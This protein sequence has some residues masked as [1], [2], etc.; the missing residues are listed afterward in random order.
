MIRWGEEKRNAD[1]GY[2]CRLISQGPGSEKP[3][4]I[5]SDARRKTDID[6]FMVVKSTSMDSLLNWVHF[7]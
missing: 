5:V 7:L 2:F 1:P 4:W 6:Y 3:V